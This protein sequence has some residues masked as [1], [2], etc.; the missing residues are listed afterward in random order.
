MT[1]NMWMVKSNPTSDMGAVVRGYGHGHDAPFLHVGRLSYYR[2]RFW[3]LW[4]LWIE[5]RGSWKWFDTNLRVVS[6]SASR[7][8]HDVGLPV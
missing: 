5:S 1:P 6:D 4:T 3:P 7:W 2:R 8:S